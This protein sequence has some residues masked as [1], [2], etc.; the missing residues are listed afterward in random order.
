MHLISVRLQTLPPRLGIILH[1]VL[2]LHIR[3]PTDTKAT[4]HLPLLLLLLFKSQHNPSLPQHLIGTNR[5]IPAPK[6][7]RLEGLHTPAVKLANVTMPIP[8]LNEVLI[9]PNLL[10]G[11]MAKANFSSIFRLNASVH[12]REFL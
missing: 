1:L 12:G 8:T 7:L 2:A 3:L 4:R 5:A 9:R 11:G 10:L 6:R